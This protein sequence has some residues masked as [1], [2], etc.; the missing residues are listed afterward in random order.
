MREGIRH[1]IAARG[2]LQAVVA[3][4]FRRR[5]GA[6][7]VAGLQDPPSALGIRRPDAGQ[8]IDRDRR[9][10]WLTGTGVL[11]L[12]EV[13]RD[14]DRP[15][16]DPDFTP[17]H[18]LLADCREADLSQLD[19]AKMRVIGA[20]SPLAPTAQRAF[21]VRIFQDLDEA[22]AWLTEPRSGG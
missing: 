12:E 19:A 16:A 5:H 17:E 1:G 21:V 7:D 6:L 3:D 11:A 15:R 22:V 8:R 2:L 20:R 9:I 4:R 18:N 13:L 14:Q 10:V